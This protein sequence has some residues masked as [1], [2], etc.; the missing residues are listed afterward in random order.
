[1]FVDNAA[2]HTGRSGILSTN[3]WR[4]ED[5]KQWLLA[6]NVPFPG[7]LGYGNYCKQWTM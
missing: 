6:K 7:V 1:M 2:H 4:K 5:V 3:P